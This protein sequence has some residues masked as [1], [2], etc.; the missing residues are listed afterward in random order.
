[1]SQ[2]T[3]Q[4]R[5]VVGFSRSSASIAALLWALGEAALR[6]AVVS[7]VHAW[8][9]SGESRA[10]YAP[11]G[12]WRCRDDELAAVR[13]EIVRAVAELTPRPL[14]PPAPVIDQGPA[15]QVLLRHAETADLLV[16]GSRPYDPDSP[17]PMGAVLAACV[18]RSACPVVVVT[19]GR[20]APPRQARPAA[21]A[22][23]GRPPGVT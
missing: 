16:L 22:L 8:Q 14:L 1:M 19:P 7:P 15:V 20:V 4:P 23:S 9:W 18:P 17:A 3:S 12:T 11:M 13:R 2:K 6:E 5:I 21:L 10:S